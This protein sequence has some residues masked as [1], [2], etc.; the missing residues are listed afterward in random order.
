[1]PASIPRGARN[2]FTIYK[3]VMTSTC[4]PRGLSVLM[5]A[6]YLSVK[7]YSVS[8]DEFERHCNVEFMKHVLPMLRRPTTPRYNKKKHVKLPWSNFLIVNY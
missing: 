2:V 7:K 5:S 1:M 3:E 4:Q 6:W 8:S